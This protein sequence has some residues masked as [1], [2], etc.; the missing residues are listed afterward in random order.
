MDDCFISRCLLAIKRKNSCQEI[1]W[2]LFKIL[3]RI[4]CFPKNRAFYFR[5]CGKDDH[6]EDSAGNDFAGTDSQH[7]Q[8]DRKVHTVSVVKNERHDHRVGYDRW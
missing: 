3:F 6:S 4:T 1:T 8:R 5:K 2:Q 7:H